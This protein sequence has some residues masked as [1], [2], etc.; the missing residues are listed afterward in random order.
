MHRN[1]RC[2]CD[3]LRQYISALETVIEHISLIGLDRRAYQ[4]IEIASKI[5][6]QQHEQKACT[7]P[8]SMKR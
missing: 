1:D 2:N 8:E 6:L 7:I 5:N 4:L 3:S